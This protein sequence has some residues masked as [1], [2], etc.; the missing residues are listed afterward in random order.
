MKRIL[1]SAKNLKIGDIEKSLINL[2]NYLL[3]NNYKV[4]LVLEEKNGELLEH[5]DK[6][7]KIIQY[8]SSK[9]TKPF[10]KIINFTKKTLFIIK[11]KNRFDTSISFATYSKSG[12]FVARM[13][14]KNSILWCHDDYLNLYKGDKLKVEKFFEELYYDY[15][16]K[17]VFA[18]KKAQKTFLEVFPTQKNT[19][20]CNNLIDYKKIYSQTEGN[21]KLKYE[22]GRTTFLNISRHDEN[23][24]K[25]TRIIEAAK[26]L[27]QENFKFRIIFVGS[28]KDTNKYKELVKKYNL[29]K[30]VIFVGAKKN[31]YPYY[32]ISN[33]VIVSSDYEGYPVVFW[34]SYLLNRPIITT[35]VSDYE[36]IQNKRGFVVQKNA[37]SM[38]KAMKNFIENGY[39]IKK[40]FDIRKYNKQ[41]A[42]TLEKIL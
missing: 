32:K 36:E 29:Q 37:K 7:V 13:A 41:I 8:A 11:Y 30:N 23:Q 26:M 3:E 40:H 31:P 27:K 15:F 1:L 4:T 39:V 14:S 10:R 9:A 38:Y 20:Y 6:K 19:Y 16:S 28:G 22:E 12:S 2:I 18:S 35:D 34:E 5:M 25:L 24:K 42:N 33:C 21:I 17:V